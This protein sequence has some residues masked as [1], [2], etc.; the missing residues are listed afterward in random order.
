MCIAI[1]KPEGKILSKAVLQNCYQ[2]NRDGAG[3]AYYNPEI[4]EVCIQKGFFNFDFFYE[5]FSKFQQYKCLVHFR[6][7]THRSV[8]GLNCH[9]WRVNDDLVFIH[10][11][12]ISGMNANS[13]LSDTGNFC[14]SVL[15][16]MLLEYPD[17]HLTDEFKWLIENSVGTFNKIIFLDSH[18]NHVIINSQAGT[19]DEGCWFSN[20]TYKSYGKPIKVLDN[21]E[22]EPETTPTVEPAPAVASE[23]KETHNL[24]ENEEMFS[25]EKIVEL[26]DEIIRTGLTEIYSTEAAL[27]DVLEKLNSRRYAHTSTK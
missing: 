16:E 22:P 26:D 1:L 4:N 7:A 10:N 25:E 19:W 13:D 15:K 6:V 17:F 20:S 9:P 23:D 14:D 8:N 27:D 11:G 21:G 3:F 2:S 5:E 18:G 12:T 24:S